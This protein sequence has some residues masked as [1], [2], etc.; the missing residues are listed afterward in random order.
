MA[1]ELELLRYAL[2]NMRKKAVTFRRVWRSAPHTYIRDCTAVGLNVKTKHF[3]ATLHLN[4]QYLDWL[5]SFKIF[6]KVLQC[7]YADLKCKQYHNMT[8]NTHTG[9]PKLTLKSPVDRSSQARP[10]EWPGPGMI[11]KRYW[12]SGCE[13]SRTVPGVI[14]RTTW[15]CSSFAVTGDLKK[16]IWNGMSSIEL[17]FWR[18]FIVN[19]STCTELSQGWFT[20]S[21]FS[22]TYRYKLYT[23]GSRRSLHKLIKSVDCV[24]RRLVYV[25]YYSVLQYY[26]KHPKVLAAGNNGKLCFQSCNGQIIH[27]SKIIWP[28]QIA[29]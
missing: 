20:I 8:T 19:F 1:P 15:R 18:K 21:I 24:Y 25:Y 6:S 3:Y 16:N 14:S 17:L 9:H 11:A 28:S 4:L 2:P 22:Q 23:R 10:S 13:G 27:N 29:N 5:Y 12:A 7:R 26:Y